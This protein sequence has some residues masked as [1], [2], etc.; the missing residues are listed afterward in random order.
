MSLSV[1][2]WE[3]PFTL[4][5]FG[6]TLQLN[7]AVTLP[8]SGDTVHYLLNPA[9]CEALIPIR[10]QDDNVPQGD[11]EQTHERFY[12]GYLMTL[13]I[14]MW[15]TDNKPACDALLQEAS[16]ELM[17]FVRRFTNQPT[18]IATSQDNRVFWTPDGA[19]DRRMIRRCVLN[20]ALTWT[21]NDGIVQANFQVKSMY[22]Y[23]WN[24]TEIPTD[25]PS[26]SDD[27]LTNGGTADFWPVFR[28][29]GPVDAFT[30]INQDA[31]DAEGNEMK[32]VYDGTAIPG[33]SYGEIDTFRNTMYLNGDQNNLKGSLSMADTDFFPL[34]VGDNTLTYTS[35]DPSSSLRILWQNAWA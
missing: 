11:G 25:I 2:K 13:A 27:V 26:G 10:V 5:A 18:P 12:Q 23:A 28:V 21:L 7:D 8:G 32:I 14:Q 6:E 31:L 34:I 17:L 30:I 9:E 22:P 15:E 35:S 4:S 24:S 33:G 29:F 19:G 1:S 16:D 20:E 3:V